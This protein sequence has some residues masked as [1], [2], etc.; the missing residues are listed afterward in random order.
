[1]KTTKKILIVCAL[2]VELKIVKKHFIENRPAHMQVDFLQVWMGNLKSSLMLTEAL[3]QKSYD[4]V[5]NIWVCGYREKRES[6]IQIVRSVYAPTQKEILVPVFFEFAKLESIL[7]SEIPVYKEEKL[8]WENYVDMESHALEMVCEHFHIP[9]LLLKV[10]V[11]KIGEETKNFDTQLAEKLL[12]EHIDYTKLSENISSYLLSLPA[13]TSHESYKQHYSFTA[14]EEILLEKYI[15]KYE[16][17]SQKD[18]SPF[19]QKQKHLA[20]KDFLRTLEDTNTSL[21]SL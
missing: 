11:D 9:R 15:A 2:G 3:S 4:F 8:L 21:A 17:L 5:L 7:C 1:M 18:F 20:K 12:R 13:K 10:P 6:C 19:F 14:S 16:S